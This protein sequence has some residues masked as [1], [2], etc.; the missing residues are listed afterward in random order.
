M[1]EVHPTII[2]WQ[3]ERSELFKRWKEIYGGHPLQNVQQTYP[4]GLGNCLAGLLGGGTG[5]PYAPQNPLDGP[6]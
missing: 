2:R 4:E 5:D 6:R 1:M 3:H